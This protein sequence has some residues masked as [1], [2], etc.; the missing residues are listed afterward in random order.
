MATVVFGNTTIWD[1]GPTGKGVG[2]IP[3]FAAGP[4]VSWQMDTIPRTAIKVAKLVH[5]DA[6]QIVVP[7]TYHCT[8]AER[9][10]IRNLINGLRA[11]EG[12]LTLPGSDSYTNCILVS[13]EWIR[14][15]PLSDPVT[16]TIKRNWRLILQFER[17]YLT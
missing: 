13:Q 12:T 1:D 4:I 17:L 7:L 8:D 5:T 2:R 10:T 11:T 15:A 14:G 6:G 3:S 9:V 16:S